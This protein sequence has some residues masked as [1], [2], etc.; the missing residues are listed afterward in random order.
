MFLPC[1][2]LLLTVCFLSWPSIASP[3]PGTLLKDP[4]FAEKCVPCHQPLKDG[5]IKRISFMRKTPEGWETSIQRMQR[6]WRVQLQEVEKR[7]LIKLLCQ[8]LSLAPA[9][10]KKVFYALA[11]EDPREE[12]PDEPLKRTCSRC[13]SYATFAAQRRSQE[14][15]LKL[16]PFHLALYPT[17]VYQMRE[18]DWPAMAEKTLKSIARTFPF[19]TKEWKEWKTRPPKSPE[20]NLTGL[21]RVF[22]FQPGRGRYAGSLEFATLG[23]G[24]YEVKRSVRYEEGGEE[25][26]TG[27]GT[28]YSGYDLRV[29]FGTDG[30]GAKGVF[31]LSDTGKELAGRWRFLDKPHVA[32]EETS[33]RPGKEAKLL[34]LSPS[35]LKRDSSKVRL[36]IEGVN[37]PSSLRPQDGFLGKGVRVSQVLNSGQEGLA[38]EVEVEKN[39]SI[40]RQDISVGN[41][42][43]KGLL[44]I[45]DRADYLRVTPEL[46]LARVGGVVNPL[47]GEQFMA[48]AYSNGKDG[49]P[50]T[51]DDL[52]L[53][54]VK[55]G[56]SLE[57]YFHA[58][59]ERDVEFVGKV[60]ENGLFLPSAEGPN[61]DRPFQ[62]NNVGNVWVVAT[63]RPEGE[64]RELQA[65]A[66]LLVTV[67]VYLQKAIR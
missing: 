26:W 28:L 30:G 48:V 22:G 49:L 65:R 3:A 36:L 47:T 4:L 40:G 12:V 52:E 17:L 46:G 59:G 23:D 18:M 42:K 50:H 60:D 6:L 54:P 45:Y 15:W 9:E 63:Y 13:H 11:G 57:E 16:K 33:F 58:P 29:H 2:L 21:W 20:K 35:A 38:L 32:G 64:D 55:A 39:A 67:P 43:G 19:E 24:D 8:E 37:L 25:S 5:R 27:K 31:A 1:W 62:T 56:W 41:A 61:S 53:G 34:R 10:S 44:T 14:E 51:K 66:Y 7:G